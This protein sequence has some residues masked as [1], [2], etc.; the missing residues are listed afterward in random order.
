[1]IDPRLGDA[2]CEDHQIMKWWF[3]LGFEEIVLNHDDLAIHKNMHRLLIIV[4]TIYKL[5][6]KLCNRV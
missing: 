1:M 5:L 2:V 4:I 3:D 6:I